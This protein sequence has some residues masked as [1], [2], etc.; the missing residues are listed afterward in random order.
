MIKSRPDAPN[1][2]FICRRYLEE[3][4][5]WIGSARLKIGRELSSSELDV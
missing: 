5:Q 3:I 2:E 1:G 4:A